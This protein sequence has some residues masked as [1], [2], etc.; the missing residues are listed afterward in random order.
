MKINLLYLFVFGLLISCN[1]AKKEDVFFNDNLYNEILN[2]QKKNPIPN[3]SLYKLFIYEV[4]FS[5]TRDTLLTI[6]VSPTGIRS[7][8]S[9]GIYRDKV[10]KPSYIIDSQNLSNRFMKIYKKDSIKSYILEGTPPHIDIIYPV[11]KYKIEG[12][13]LIFIDSL[14]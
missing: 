6:T 5:K 9:Y 14:K 11:Y 10:T 1:N 4:S 2:Y 3:K 13:K 7:K 12:D 8:N